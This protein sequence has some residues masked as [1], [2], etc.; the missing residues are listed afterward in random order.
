MGGFIESLTVA[1][2]NRQTAKNSYNSEKYYNKENI[3]FTLG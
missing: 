1:R 3:G 2:E